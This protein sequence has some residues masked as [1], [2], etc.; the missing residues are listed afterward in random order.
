MSFGAMLSL[1]DWLNWFNPFSHMAN[2]PVE[3][4]AW[5]PFLWLSII[6]LAGIV[7]GLLGWHRREINR[8]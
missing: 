8:I 3:D 4:I 2:Y 6:G 7:L 5:A 1:P